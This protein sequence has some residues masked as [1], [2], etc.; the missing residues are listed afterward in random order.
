LALVA[1]NARFLIL[2]GY[3]VPNL[4]TRVLR[5]T[6]DRLSAAWPVRYAYPLALAETFVDPQQFHG[7]VYQAGGCFAAVTAW[8]A[9]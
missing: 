8:P 5:L 1:N 6:L 9:A 3:A 7:T 2:P 4:A